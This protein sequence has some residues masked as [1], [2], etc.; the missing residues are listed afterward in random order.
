MK[1]NL[2]VFAVLLLVSLGFATEAVDPGIV[3]ACE[4][5]CC[6]DSGGAWDGYSCSGADDTYYECVSD[7]LEFTTAFSES[8]CC[9][10][11]LILLVAGAAIF[12][13][14]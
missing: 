12:V 3:E 5:A 8:C 4:E 11:A 10:S 13:N 14:K 6:E 1:L 2:F 9:P 7:C